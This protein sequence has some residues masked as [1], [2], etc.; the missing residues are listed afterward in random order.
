MVTDIDLLRKEIR[1]RA[2]RGLKEMDLLFAHFLARYLDTLTSEAL[3]ELRD[4][5]LCFDQDLLAWLIEGQLPAN[6][7]SALTAQ[8]QACARQ[9]WQGEV[10]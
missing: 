2:R 9:L 6:R 8:L 4:L 5:L 3:I 7:R 10:T 1:F